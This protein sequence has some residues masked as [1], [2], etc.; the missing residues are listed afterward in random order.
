MRYHYYPHVGELRNVGNLTVV[1]NSESSFYTISW[2]A[3]TSLDPST[4]DPNITYC[5]NITDS[6]STEIVS[7]CGS[8][9][10]EYIFNQNECDGCSVTV[11]PVHGFCDRNGPQSNATFPTGND[12]LAGGKGL[13]FLIR[14]FNVYFQLHQ[15]LHQPTLK[16]K[17]NLMEVSSTGL[18]Q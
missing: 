10:T 9:T 6:S 3:V 1:F 14:S 16:L 17:Q 7:Q 5:V 8:N 12:F 18:Q 13:A 2:D 4:I 15:M 11:T